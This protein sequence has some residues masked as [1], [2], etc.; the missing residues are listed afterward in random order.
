MELTAKKVDEIFRDCLFKDNELIDG[1]PVLK[2]IIVEGIIHTFGFHPGRIE[3]H[4]TEITKLLMEL[5]ATF[6]KDGWSFLEACITKDRIQWTGLHERMEQL[7]AL[8]MAI[9]K[10]KYVFPRKM[11]ETLPGGMP[12][13]VI[14]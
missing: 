5:P 9:D 12:Y 1:K 4:E 8:G 11:W 7:F 3:A 14:V 10:V 6:Q 13:L 2:E